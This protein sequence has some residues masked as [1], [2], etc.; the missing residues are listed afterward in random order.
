ML[1][2]EGFISRPLCRKVAMALL[3][4]LV[5]I[6]AGV[7]LQGCAT[8]GGGQAPAPAAPKIAG[9]DSC[10][11]AKNLPG[12]Q[13]ALTMAFAADSSGGLNGQDTAKLQSTAK[14]RA[15]CLLGLAQPDWNVVWGPV[16]TVRQNPQNPPDGSCQA[17]AVPAAVRGQYIPANTMFVAQKGSEYFV[18]IAGTNQKSAFAWCDEDFTVTLTQWPYGNPPS[19]AQITQG[20]LDGLNILLAMK[21]LTQP[22]D[23]QSL[24]A[25]LAKAAS[26]GAIQISVAGHSLGGAQSPVVGLWLKET[27]SQWDRSGRS[28]V[29]VYAFAGATP[30]N[31][32]FADYLNSR[33]SG[34]S[35]A[36]INNTLDLVPHAWNSTT[37][38]EIQNLYG[39]DIQPSGEIAL[40][41]MGLLQEA[42]PEYTRLGQNGQQQC[43]TGTLLKQDQLNQATLKECKDNP[44]S[45]SCPCPLFAT[46]AGLADTPPPFVLEALDQHVCAYPKQLGLPYLLLQEGG[47]Q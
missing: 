29:N 19:N 27:Q 11:A 34:D 2:K 43:I 10:A 35:L 24:S 16:I 21:D 28:T 37:M 20:T 22:A 47:C 3:G 41:L 45:E 8:A 26:N 38:N 4:P 36:V 42:G 25:F 46:L 9:A 23:Q 7:S 13:V 39:P 18:G 1:K 32:G 6:G 12:A 33:F 44:L 40:L 15:E 14:T 31:A 17:Y 5:A 30:G